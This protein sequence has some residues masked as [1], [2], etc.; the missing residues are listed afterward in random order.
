VK[1]RL[2]IAVLGPLSLAAPAARAADQT[3]GAHQHITVEKDEDEGGTVKR[4]VCDDEWNADGPGAPCRR[5]K[6]T[7]SSDKPKP[8]K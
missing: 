6:P 4:C 5:A 3:C 2:V 1:L 8:R 7:K